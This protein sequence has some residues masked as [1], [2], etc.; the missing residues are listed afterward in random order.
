MKE[1]EQHIRNELKRIRNQIR[2]GDESEIVVWVLPGILACSQRPLRDNPQF[3]GRSPLPLQAKSL[4]ISWVERIKQMGI[5]SII[6]LLENRQLERYY[7]QGGLGLH[8]RGLLGYYESR[9]FEV[10]HFPMTDYQ[11]PEESYMQKVLEGFDAL[12]KPVLLHC[13]AAIDRTTPVAA[14]IV[15]YTHLNAFGTSQTRQTL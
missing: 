8:E 12:P 1:L 2:S 11:Q 3:G 7:I 4:V 6:C 15:R 13:S 9:G 10:R 5:L 14:Y